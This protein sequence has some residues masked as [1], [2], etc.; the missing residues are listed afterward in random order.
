MNPSFDRWNEVR[1]NARLWWAGEL[2]RPLIQIRV[3]GCDPERP[4]PKLAR[5]NSATLYDASV[6]AE[7]IV[8]RWD[9]ELSCIRHEGDAFPWIHPNFGAGVVAAFLGARTSHATGTVWFHPPRDQ[10]IAD[11]HF[12]F[13]P[14]NAVYRMQR[15]SSNCWRNPGKKPPVEAIRVYRALTIVRFFSI[16]FSRLTKEFV[17]YGNTGMVGFITLQLTRNEAGGIM[18]L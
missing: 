11:L 6:P 18:A 14:D 16:A 3:Y 2:E 5:V 10:E 15:T 12:R 1:R 7:A 8:E 9:Y 13:D 4:A 17:P